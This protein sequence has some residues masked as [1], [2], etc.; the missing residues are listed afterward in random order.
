MMN[1]ALPF[2]QGA[3]HAAAEQAKAT[4]RQDLR[5][6]AESPGRSLGQRPHLEAL[7]RLPALG[8]VSRSVRVLFDLG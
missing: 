7:A 3:L 6:A 8:S 2:A 5:R 4:A 1:P